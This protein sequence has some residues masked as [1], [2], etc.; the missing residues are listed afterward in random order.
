MV[1]NSPSF[2]FYVATNCHSLLDTRALNEHDKNRS[3]DEELSV[4]GET[5]FFVQLVAQ[6]Q[7]HHKIE[8]LILLSQ[9]INVKENVAFALQIL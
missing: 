5:L 9:Y 1:I 2:L 7:Y 6:V 8:G 3:F 4:L